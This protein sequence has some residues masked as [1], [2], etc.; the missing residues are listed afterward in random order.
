MWF[1]D[2]EHF[3]STCGHEVNGFWFPRVTKILDVKAKPAIEFFLK[4]MESYSAAEEVKNKS[5][6]EGSLVH[7]VVQKVA[8]GEPVEIP[9][10]IAPAVSS[11][12]KLRAEKGIIFYPEFIERP[13]WS[14]AHRYAGTVDALCT[15]D[16]KFGVL[17]IKTSPNFY[18]EYNLQTAAY[19]Q[20]LQEYSVK[21]SIGLPED[22]QTR[23]ILR[24]NQHRVCEKCGATLREK[25]GRT[26]IKNGSASRRTNGVKPC[27]EEEHVW[28]DP[29]GDVELKEFP[30][31][32]RDVKAFM[33]AK[34]LWE[35]END[36][37]LRQIGYL[38]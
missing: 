31:Y 12:E 36:Y 20:A 14:V 8:V 32:Y 9:R 21:M 13:V 11:F 37:W 17:D 6:E 33:A 25:G 26:K 16:G 1:R 10:E 28:C 34:T 30:Y 7:A 38:K 29:V 19:L 2:G 5:A 15:I 27:S 35:W 22:I 23:W 4:E 18:P 24:I 3:K